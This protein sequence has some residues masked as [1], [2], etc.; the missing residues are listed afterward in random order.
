MIALEFLENQCDLSAQPGLERGR[1][2]GQETFQEVI[3][4]AQVSDNGAWTK[5][6][7]WRRIKVI[8]FEKNKE[9]GGMG[10]CYYVFMQGKEKREKSRNSPSF[11][12]W[13]GERMM[14]SF[15]T[16]Q[17]TEEGI[18]QMEVHGQLSLGHFE[19]KIPFKSNYR[20]FGNICPSVSNSILCNGLSS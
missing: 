6:Q 18:A 11:L 8:Q 7:Q 4:S 15:V 20:V 9:G 2:V 10:L 16:L 3:E 13:A 1:T 19:L 5:Y 17:C 14:V 12:A